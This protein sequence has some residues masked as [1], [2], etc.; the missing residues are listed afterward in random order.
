M[1]MVNLKEISS[2]EQ[3]LKCTVCTVYCPVLAVNPAFPGPKQAGPDQERLRLK[4]PAYFDEALKYCTNCKRCEVACPSGVRI[5]DIIQ[6]AKLKYSKKKP[7]LREYFL[8]HTDLIGSLSSPLA[9]IVNTALKL[10]VTKVVLDKALKVDKHRQ[11]PKYSGEKFESWYKKHAD[12]QKKYDKQIT[13][14]H[15]CYVNYNYPRLGK[16][17]VKVMNALGYGV[18]LLAKEKCCGVPAISNGFADQARKQGEVNL[19]SIRQSVAEGRKVIS[20][21]TSCMMTMRDEYPHILD[22]DNSDVR[23]EMEISTRFL[24]R[25]IQAGRIDLKKLKLKKQQLKVAYHSPCHLEKLG[26]EFYSIAILRMIPGIDLTVLAPNCCGIAGTYGFKKENYE[27]SQKIGSPLFNEIDNGGFD[28][29]ATDCETCK[30]Q[31]EMST[32]S[33]VKHP[34]SVIADMLED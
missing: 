33:T 19:A 25:E 2:F 7:G 17:F 28:F 13:Y 24:F 23:E 14:F 30:W 18:Q 20:T 6:Q 11:F 4:D 29:V 10:P 3:C 8:A 16:D 34:I 26:W 22:L 31:I 5:G 27:F 15:G 9:P 21:S 1:E 12:E 32:K